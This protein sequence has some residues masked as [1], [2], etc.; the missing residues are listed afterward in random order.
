MRR[1]AANVLLILLA[2]NTA[3]FVLY[4]AG[5][6]LGALRSDTPA[7]L[8][9]VFAGTMP[10]SNASL[11]VHMVAGAV[12]TIGAPL[13]ALPM[14]RR[15]RPELHRRAGYV[16]A[17]L[18]AATGFAG[19]VYIALEGT[20]GG[21]W[22][23]LWFAIYGALMIWAAVNTVYYALCK[24]LSRHF[25]W[26]IRFVILAVGSWIFRMHYALWEITTGGIASND[27]FTG[28]FDRVQV[29]A[30]FLPYLLIAEIIIRRS[31]SPRRTV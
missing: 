6:G 26:A 23:S 14:L 10:I 5:L 29:F 12:L 3:W 25:A 20:V 2:V 30:F 17:A 7:E 24:D 15:R 1:T 22:M 11:A 13:Q 21:W 8:S 31:A 27:G 4:S 28:T 19:L 16:L 18:A 9:R